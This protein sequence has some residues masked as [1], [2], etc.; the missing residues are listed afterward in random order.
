MNFHAFKRFIDLVP[1]LADAQPVVQVEEQ[2]SDYES[3]AARIGNEQWR[4]RTA[5]ITP[6][7]PGAFV[8]VWK[9]GEGGSTRPFTAEESMSGLLVFVEGQERFGVFQFTKAHLISLGYVSS[10]L[11]PGKRGFR[12]YPAWCTD[13]NPQASRSQRAQGA[14]FSELPPSNASRPVQRP[15]GNLDLSSSA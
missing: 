15:S 14:A 9:R 12:V 4:I 5:R 3:G 13:L 11:H 8:A 1:A 2:N 6:T 10:D 7:K